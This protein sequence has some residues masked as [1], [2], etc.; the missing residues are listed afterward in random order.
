MRLTAT[1]RSPSLGWNIVEAPAS[2]FRH[3]GRGFNFKV[4]SD[5]WGHTLARRQSP[6]RGD[7]SSTP[8]C[9]PKGPG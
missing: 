5:L 8:K 1:R 6:V 7:S 2:C 4:V 9:A 3:G